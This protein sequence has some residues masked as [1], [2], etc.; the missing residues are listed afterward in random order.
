[1]QKHNKVTHFSDR[2]Y[3]I[4]KYFKFD[5]FPSQIHNQYIETAVMAFH[6]S[7]I[8]AVFKAIFLNP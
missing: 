5:F 6:A 7:M 2:M 8:T 1:M 3:T 4:N